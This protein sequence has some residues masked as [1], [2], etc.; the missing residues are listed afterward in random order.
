MKWNSKVPIPHEEQ[1]ELATGRLTALFSKEVEG[2]ERHRMKSLAEHSL[3]V[4]AAT[5][6]VWLKCSAEGFALGNAHRVG[7]LVFSF[8]SFK[9]IIISY[10]R[11]KEGCVY[12][13][14]NVSILTRALHS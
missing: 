2:M 3:A 12:V 4:T 14:L 5:G 9:K 1:A 11:T 6:S 10:I 7:L 8:L 13:C